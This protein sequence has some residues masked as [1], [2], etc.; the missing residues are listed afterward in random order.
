LDSFTEQNISSVSGEKTVVALTGLLSSV[1]PRA[2]VASLSLAV[3]KDTSQP[4]D[5]R[6]KAER[7]DVTSMRDGFLLTDVLL[8]AMIQSIWARL[9][10]RVYSLQLL[11][12]IESLSVKR[13][14]STEILTG[15]QQSLALNRIAVCALLEVL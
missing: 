4:T 14:V 6:I 10:R 11:W 7:S 15:T 9:T 8:S 13:K 1:T 3:V 2:I 5:N 12:S